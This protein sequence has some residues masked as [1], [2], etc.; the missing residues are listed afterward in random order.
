M[1]RMAGNQSGVLPEARSLHQRLPSGRDYSQCWQAS[2]TGLKDIQKG[3][4]GMGSE[5]SKEC[6]AGFEP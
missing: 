1:T 6:P 5:V 2:V 3:V 4:Q